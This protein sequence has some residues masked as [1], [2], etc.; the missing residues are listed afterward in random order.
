MCDHQFTLPN[1]ESTISA[2][3]RIFTDCLLK[4]WTRIKTPYGLDEALGSVNKTDVTQLDAGEA[5]RQETSVIFL[6]SG[7]QAWLAY[8][9]VTHNQGRHYSGQKVTAETI[10]AFDQLPREDRIRVAAAVASTES[11]ATVKDA[12]RKLTASQK[13]RR[14]LP[15]TPLP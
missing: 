3:L 9:L 13:R 8:F 14:K 1:A 10:R 4:K 5:A 6:N 2:S 12:I 11:H 15:Q 7:F